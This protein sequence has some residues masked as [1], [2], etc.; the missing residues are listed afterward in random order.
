MTE[1]SKWPKT[2]TDR[3]GQ[4]ER[5]GLGLELRR[6]R[7]AVHAR[8]VVRTCEGYVGARCTCGAEKINRGGQAAQASTRTLRGW[9]IE[10]LNIAPGPTNKHSGDW[11]T[12]PTYKDSGKFEI[13]IRTVSSLCTIIDQLVFINEMQIKNEQLISTT[14]TSYWAIKS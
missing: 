6:T 10:M 4:T 13:Y 3:F 5:P 2:E 12:C 7:Q 1:L 14:Y 9:E 8:R 11:P